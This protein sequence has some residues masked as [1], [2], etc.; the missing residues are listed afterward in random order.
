MPVRERKRIA[1]TTR[2]RRLRRGVMVSV[3]QMIEIADPFYVIRSCWLFRHHNEFRFEF[4][5]YSSFK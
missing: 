2:K 3:R 5:C 1:R 4:I